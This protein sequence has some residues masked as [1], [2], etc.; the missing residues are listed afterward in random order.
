M[1]QVGR[2]STA[3]LCSIVA[4]PIAF[5]LGF[6]FVLLFDPNYHDGVSGV[7]GFV[8]AVIAAVV[9]FRSLWKRQP[10]HPSSPGKGQ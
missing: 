10:L 9:T 3:V 5:I 4:L 1:S 8:F 7:G 6:Y 2:I